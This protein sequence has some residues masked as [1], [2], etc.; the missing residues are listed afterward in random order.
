MMEWGSGRAGE[1]V[2][3]GQE[4]ARESGAEGARS[5]AAEADRPGNHQRE[6]EQEPRDDGVPSETDAEGVEENEGAQ[7]AGMTRVPIPTWLLVLI[8][9]AVVLVTY[10]AL[11]IAGEQR[12]QSC[13]QAVNARVGIANDNLTRL[14]RNTSVNRCSHSPF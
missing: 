1:N 11:R 9:L 13:V 6:P 4:E 5:G 14:V 12:Y 10:S 8:V 3:G 2:S 7:R